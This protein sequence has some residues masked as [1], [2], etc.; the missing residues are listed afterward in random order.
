MRERRQDN[1]TKI[2][3]ESR[4]MYNSYYRDTKGAVHQFFGVVDASD[5]YYYG[6]RRVDDSKVSLLSCVMNIESFNYTLVENYC[7]TCGLETTRTETFSE[8]YGPKELLIE[9]LERK[10]CGNCAA[11]FQTSPQVNN[12][13]CLINEEYDKDESE[14]TGM[15]T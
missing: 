1:W 5:D 15:E 4:D 14:E 2:T 6:M 11:T 10:V 9:G 7:P 12:Q 13:R 3:A 8:M